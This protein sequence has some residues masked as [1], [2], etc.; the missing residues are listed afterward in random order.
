MVE[1]VADTNTSGGKFPAPAFKARREAANG[2]ASRLPINV[3]IVF[4]DR[5]AILGVKGTTACSGLLRIMF[6]VKIGRVQ[7]YHTGLFLTTV[8]V[9]VTK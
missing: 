7:N 8:P 2:E 9:H 4:V 6:A 5:L 1:L 3:I